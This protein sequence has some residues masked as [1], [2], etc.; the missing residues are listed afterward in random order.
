MEIYY[1]NVLLLGV[2]LQVSQVMRLSIGIG[3]GIG[4]GI[5]SLSHRFDGECPANLWSSPEPP[6]VR[7]RDPVFPAS[8]AYAPHYDGPVARSLFTAI[9]RHITT[10]KRCIIPILLLPSVIAGI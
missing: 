1:N 4:F 6:K 2:E 3:I 7:R 9:H 8:S 5:I 10:G